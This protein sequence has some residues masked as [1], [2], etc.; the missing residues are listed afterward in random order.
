MK[1]IIA[2]GHPAHFH[3]FKNLIFNSNNIANIKI[4]I[5]DKDI[6]R[7]LLDEFKLPYEVLSFK[8]GDETLYQKFKK[9]ITSSFA[10]YKITKNFKPNLIIGSLT[11][12]GLIGRLTR[13]HSLF[14]AEDDF[15]YT[16]LQGSITYPFI[17]YVISP[18]A[19]S[20]GIFDFKKIGY[21]GYQKLA[22]L[23]PLH[24]TPEYKDIEHLVDKDRKLF[25]IRL[26]NLKAYHDNGIYGL[27]DNNVEILLKLLEPFGRVFISAE[28]KIPQ[29]FYKYLVPLK[30][31]QIHSLLYFSDMFIGDSQ[32]MAVEAS[33]LG[34]PSI[35]FNDFA[36]KI[37]VLEELEHK[38]G[39]TYGIK[40]S[41]FNKLICKVNELL[42]I[43]NLREVFQVRKQ[44]MLL[45]KIDVTAFMVW[46]IES[47][48][49]SIKIMKENPDF[50]NIFKEK[51]L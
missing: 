1:I 37:S 45:E 17:N 14:F 6:L 9:I 34:V 36:G 42:L 18:E 12:I 27:S 47:Y 26:A 46:L 48:P 3:L 39:L 51:H 10:L 40:A 28:R 25:F 22:Y 2:L 21:S 7:N 43:P 44:K 16:Y 19:T 4:V 29:K 5:T 20:L 49:K 38:Y 35:R 31:N 8:K 13:T 24:F 11:Q 15:K 30:S 50:Q 32:S 33:M 41:E 23:H